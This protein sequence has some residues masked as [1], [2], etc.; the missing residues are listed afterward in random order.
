MTKSLHHEAELVV[1]IGKE[2]L[3]I[4]KETAMNH[5]FGYAVGCDLTR[6]D[7]QAEAKKLS[8]PWASAKG[9]DYS[10][11][12]GPVVPKEA[13]QDVHSSDTLPDTMEILLEVNGDV[14]QRS[15]IGHMIWN[16]PEIVSYLSQY[17]R[18]KPGDLIMTGTPAGV[19]SLNVG[20]F[21]VISC[22]SLPPCEFY[23]GDPES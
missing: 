19:Q 16:V 17:Y 3:R 10:A 2:G 6:R 11:P 14:R 4:P 1:C 8:R 23:I 5:V 13:L 15:T 21:V 18:L 20:D 22:G 9:F 7:L 12:C